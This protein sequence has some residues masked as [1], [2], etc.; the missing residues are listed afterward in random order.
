MTDKTY[1]Q[2]D[3]DA[4]VKAQVA[5]QVSQATEGLKK[6]NDELL[7]EKKAA[8]AKVAEIEADQKAAEE[9]GMKQREEYKELHERGQDTIRSLTEQLNAKNEKERKDALSLSTLAMAGELSRDTAKAGLLAE[10]AA[11]YATY[12]DGVVTYE[13]GGITVDEAKVKEHLTEKLGFLVDG[14]GNTGG[15]AVGASDGSGAVKKFSEYSAA[16]LSAMANTDPEK[17][18]KVRETA[19][20]LRR[21][22]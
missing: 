8:A 15:G 18:A 3:I 6:K 19:E 21:Q 13:I 5:E 14:S 2:E 10:Q 4:M 20:H 22:F 16:E 11:K 17:Y 9:A 12:A 7:S 1:T